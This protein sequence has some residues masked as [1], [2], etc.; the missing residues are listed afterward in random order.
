MS[1]QVYSS[2]I[3]FKTIGGTF[4]NFAATNLMRGQHQNC[5]QHIAQAEGD[6][7]LIVPLDKTDQYI[8]TF[9]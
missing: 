9:G 3:S 2:Q 8:H 6:D 4:Y 5:V 1:V 7:E